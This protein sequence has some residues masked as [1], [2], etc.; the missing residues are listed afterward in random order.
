MMFERDCT[1][2]ERRCIALALFAMLVAV[3]AHG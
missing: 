1:L 3:V 2:T